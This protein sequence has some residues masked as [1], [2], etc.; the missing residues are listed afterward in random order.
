[1]SDGRHFA[2]TPTVGVVG[3]VILERAE[4]HRLIDAILDERTAT[5]NRRLDIEHTLKLISHSL[6]CLAKRLEP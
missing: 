4:L 1:M 3:D 6:T 5:I 2:G